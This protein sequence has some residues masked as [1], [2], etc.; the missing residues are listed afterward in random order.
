[1]SDK[2]NFN[3]LTYYFT[4][5]NLAIIKFI[6]FRGPLNNY[7][8]IKNGNTAIKRQRKIKKN[9]K[10]SLNKINTGNPK[11]IKKYQLDA[12]ENIKNLYNS[13]QKVIDLFND[14]AKIKS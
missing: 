3:D 14:Y 4:S 5:P 10:L 7:N 12:I 1:M 6:G 8:E 13:R 2:I 11:Y 9:F